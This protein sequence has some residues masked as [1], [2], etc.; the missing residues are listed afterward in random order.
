MGPGSRSQ[1]LAWPGRRRLFS[2]A[3]LHRRVHQTSHQRAQIFA[4]ARTLR[5]EHGKQLLPGI[6]PEEGSADPAPE[7]LA[8]RAREW[9]HALMGAHR[10]AEPKAMAR[11]RHQMAIELDLGAEMVGCHQL[12]R[13]AA[14]DLVAA[15]HA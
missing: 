6:D 8:D 9:R 15:E 10:K 1:V 11:Q 14:D 7:I 13:L 5:H 12:R 3:S 2:R 4:L